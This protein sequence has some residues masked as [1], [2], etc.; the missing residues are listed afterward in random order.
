VAVTQS[1]SATDLQ[2]AALAEPRA[3]PVQRGLGMP[4]PVADPPAVDAPNTAPAPA[5][6]P[7]AAAGA[8]V[9]ASPDATLPISGP[10]SRMAMPASTA[11][12]AAPGATRDVTERSQLTMHDE[13]PSPHS[14]GGEGSR[15]AT[16][17]DEGVVDCGTD[18]AGMVAMG[19]AGIGGCAPG[20]NATAVEGQAVGAKQGER[21][22]PANGHLVAALLATVAIAVLCSIGGA[23]WF[24]H[25]RRE[26]VETAPSIAVR[27]VRRIRNTRASCTCSL[28]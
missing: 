13:S 3:A 14:F 20:A 4:P 12:G 25:S 9:G 27:E 16:P 26:G 21:A 18:L 7:T 11:G 2:A 1:M 6:Q 19:D 10:R 8:P 24:V 22:G 17:E 28:T 23:V 5:A 15:S